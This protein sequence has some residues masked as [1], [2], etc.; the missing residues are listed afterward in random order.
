MLFNS[1]NL[2]CTDDWSFRPSK[3]MLFGARVHSQ[4]LCLI[5][6]NIMAP[7]RSQCR[8]GA[9]RSHHNCDEGYHNS[10]RCEAGASL[11]HWFVTTA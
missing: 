7:E 10:I 6:T 4:L 5:R 8:N 3:G 9:L 2:S 11:A 1:I